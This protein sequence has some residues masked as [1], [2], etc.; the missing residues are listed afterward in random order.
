MPVVD[1][2]MGPD[3]QNLTSWLELADG[4]EARTG[5]SFQELRDMVAERVA[6]RNA[7]KEREYEI[8]KAWALEEDEGLMERGR[9]LMQKERQ[10]RMLRKLSLAAMRLH[11]SD[12]IESEQ[13]S[14]LLKAAVTAM[15]TVSRSS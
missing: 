1:V 12:L 7:M 8:A 5:K 3:G 10:G 14:A 6:E 11:G 2:P 4:L 13:G 9:H 15:Q